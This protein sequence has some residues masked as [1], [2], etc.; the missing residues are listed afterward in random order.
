LPVGNPGF[1]N[2]ASQDGDASSMPTLY[3]EL[4]SLRRNEP[5]PTSGS[6]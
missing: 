1:V 2:V 6:L 3:R 5:A 4:L